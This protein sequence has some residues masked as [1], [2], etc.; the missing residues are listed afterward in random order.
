[1]LGAEGK[2]E[3]Q[4]T[5]DGLVVTLPARKPADYAYTLKIMPAE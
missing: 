1:M 4:R 3:F 2:L 5:D